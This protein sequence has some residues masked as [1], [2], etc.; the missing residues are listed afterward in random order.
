VVDDETARAPDEHVPTARADTAMPSLP[1]VVGAAANSLPPALPSLPT[2][3]GEPLPSVPPAMPGLATTPPSSMPSMPTIA[4]EAL[5]SVPPAMPGTPTTAHPG[6]PPGRYE[7]GAEIARGGMGRVVDAT[8]TRL[9]RIVAFKE[10]LSTDADTLRRFQREIRITARL[11]HPSIVPVHDTGESTNGAPFYTM[12]KV[13][14]R[15]LERLVA[16]ADTLNQRLALIPHIVDAAQAIA[17]AHERGIVHRDIKPSN[18]LV[19][20]LGETVVIDW[21]LAK[22][23]G[24]TDEP[25]ARPQVDLSDALK[26][27]AGIVYG[28]PGFMAPEQLRGAPVNEQCDV[29]ALGATLYHLLSRK[30]P[31]YAKT[32]DEMMKAAVAS[33]PT[34]VHQLVEGVPPDLSTIVDKALAHDPRV[35]YPDARALA[36]DLQRFLT[37]QLVASHHYSP[38]EKLIRLIRKNRGLSAAVAALVVVGTLSVIRI[39]VERNRADDSAR[40]AELE[41]ADADALRT[42]AEHHAEQLTLTQARYN[43]DLNP[44]LAVAMVKPIAA[45]YW[46]EVRAIAAAAHAAGVAWIIPVSLETRS[47]EMSRDG[48][49]ALS[50]GGDGVVRL[51]DLA[52]RTT[53]TV[54]DVRGPV[55]ARFADDE[56][57]IVLWHGSQLTI[58][59][60]RTRKRREVATT[61]AIAGVE[62]IGMTAY[63]ADARGALWQLDLAG[64]APVAIPVDEPVRAIAPSPDGRW[65]ALLCENHLLLYDRTQ[66]A[67]APAEVTF[68]ETRDAGW[69]PTGDHLAALVDQSVID[70]AMAPVPT[71]VHRQMVGRREFVAHDGMRAYT[72]GPTGVSI[73]SRDETGLRRQLSGAPLGLYPA[74]GGTMVAGAT[75]GLAVISPDGDRTLSLQATR[76]EH[77]VASPSSPYVLAELAGRLLV[78]NL[79][80]IQPR[81]L[82][83]EPTGRALFASA[84]L[85]VVGGTLD[86]PPRLIDVASGAA[87]P[88]GSW[89]GL[90][91]IAASPAG[92]VVAI[93][94]AR[95]AHLVGA[96]REPEDLPGEVDIAGFATEGLLVLTTPAGAIHAYDVDHHQ[97]TPLLQPAARLLGLAWG[98]GRHPWIAAALADGT[99]WRK[100]VATGAAATVARTPPLDRQHL[101]QRDGKLIVADDGTVLF[102]AGSEIR[103]W[104]PD[105]TLDRLAATPKPLDDLGEAGPNRLLAF[106][107]DTTIYA[108]GRNNRDQLIEALPSINGSSAS[109]SPETG[110]LVVLE[111]GALDILD[112][113]VQQRWTLAPDGGG[114][115]KHPAISP[116]GRRVLAQTPRSLLVW[117]LD[118][119]ANADD[120]VRWLNTLTNAVDE[121]GPGG[122]AW[123]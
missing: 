17:H 102:L 31:H 37:G 11:E 81:R 65:I 123:R 69:S 86:A 78:W 105:G 16:A 49:R 76:I 55:E 10:A 114:E 13:S 47:L 7:L 20:E 12:R 1:T 27:R 8:D 104:R 89:Q 107:S 22:A 43:V 84:D 62:V 28:T 60:A 40:I 88:I 18:I 96:G 59:D 87:Q 83:D 19:G 82:S 117:S 45:R 110:R 5:P 61:T 2:V 66:P 67:T 121:H 101:A 111:H 58:V 32:A 122:L 41:R 51:H 119:P 26:T 4:G 80:D 112:P 23:I 3:A 113:L 50:A 100:N 44:T 79:D 120:T 74:R 14:G 72:V 35:R 6:A 48:T 98:R 71:I 15:P 103:A 94:D 97:L 115:F 109:M 54:I 39:I 25:T 53:Q 38:R 77:V 106:A 93:D 92:R 99:L 9:G 63:W 95:H 85:V 56:R 75:G 30:P 36:A 24:E 70:V 68:G 73:I 91:A 116:D 118:L 46:H 52:R 108:V 34:P 29:Y 33:A 21:G 90:R 42:K 64:S 57:Q